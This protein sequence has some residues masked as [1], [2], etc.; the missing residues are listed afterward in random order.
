MVAVD[1]GSGD[2]VVAYRNATSGADFFRRIL[3]TLGAPQA[4]PQAKVLAPT[5]AARAGG[6][7]FSAYTPDGARVLLLRFGGKARVVPVPKGARVLV[8]GL[9]AGPDGRLWIFYGNEQQ[10]Y[11]TRTKAVSGFEPV[12]TLASPKTTVLFRL[13]GEGSPDRSTCSPTSPSTA[14]PGTAPTRP[15]SFPCSRCVPRGPALA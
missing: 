4:M 10:T 3:P 15:M 11:V 14:P 12:Q 8:A 5:I 6:G 7:V 13:E 1:G 9:A 2:A